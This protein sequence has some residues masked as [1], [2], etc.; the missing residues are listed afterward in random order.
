LCS[1]TVT[2]NSDIDL[3]FT[4]HWRYVLPFFFVVVVGFLNYV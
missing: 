4:A 3:L 2:N 1:C